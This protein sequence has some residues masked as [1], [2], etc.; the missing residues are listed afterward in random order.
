MSL[1]Y[2]FWLIFFTDNINDYPDFVILNSIKSRIL[3]MLEEDSIS[4]SGK[5][6][7][8]SCSYK[9]NE[10]IDAIKIIYPGN[11]KT[12]SAKYTL[13]NNKYQAGQIIS[14]LDFFFIKDCIIQDTAKM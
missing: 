2:Y 4:D 9:Y 1:F 12:S 13:S 8:Y 6:C 11:S 5:A 7:T 3:R 14:S 10:S